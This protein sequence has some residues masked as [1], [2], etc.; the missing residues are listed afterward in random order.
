MIHPESFIPLAEKTGTI[1]DISKWVK[2]T[3]CRQNDI[4]R[5]AG[6]EPIRIAVNVSGY[7]FSS[8][9]I[10]EGILDASL[11]RLRNDID[12]CTVVVSCYFSERQGDIQGLLANKELSAF[13]D[14]RDPGM[15][16]D[17]DPGASLSSKTREW[18]SMNNLSTASAMNR[19][20]S[21]LQPLQLTYLFSID[22]R[23]RDFSCLAAISCFTG[24]NLKITP[25][26]AARAR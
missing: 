15:S 26:N 5:Q 16:M 13:F 24:G 20:T 18:L 11:K 9:N 19:K 1:I 22:S 3:A 6:I 14:D 21:I 4:W 12:M 23:Y 17:Q 2:Q 25:N 7:R 8:Q 10:F